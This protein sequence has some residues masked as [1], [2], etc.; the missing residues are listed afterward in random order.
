MSPSARREMRNAIID[1]GALQPSPVHPADSGSEEDVAV[2][3]SIHTCIC[4]TQQCLTSWV[5]HI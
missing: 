2:S 4:A 3:L 1:Y 5:D